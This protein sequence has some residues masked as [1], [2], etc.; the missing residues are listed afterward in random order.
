MPPTDV[1]T[2]DNLHEKLPLWRPDD[3]NHLYA[4]VDMG[5][6]AGPC[7][8]ALKPLRPRESALTRVVA[9]EFDSRLPL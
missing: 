3:E 8:V 5:R 6:F 1:I 7:H 2:L 4:I 9:M